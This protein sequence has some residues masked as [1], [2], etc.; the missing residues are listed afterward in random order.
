MCKKRGIKC[1]TGMAADAYVKLLKKADAEEAETDEEE[2][3]DD[4][5]EV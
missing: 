4:E 1:K 2:D 3:D 5:W